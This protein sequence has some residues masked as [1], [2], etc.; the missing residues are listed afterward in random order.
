MSNTT[1]W[2]WRF[3]IVVCE[4]TIVPEDCEDEVIVPEDCEDDPVIEIIPIDKYTDDIIDDL[5]AHHN[6][7]YGEFRWYIADTDLVELPQK[8]IQNPRWLGFKQLYDDGRYLSIGFW[9]WEKGNQ[10]AKRT[11][12]TPEQQDDMNDILPVCS[13]TEPCRMC[14]KCDFGNMTAEQEDQIEEDTIEYVM[15]CCDDNPPCY[16]WECRGCR[17]SYL[18]TKEESDVLYPEHKE[19]DDR[20][21][22]HMPVAQYKR[23]KKIQNFTEEEFKAH[24]R[25]PCSPCEAYRWKDIV[26]WTIA[27]VMDITTEYEPCGNCIFCDY[28]N[29]T[30]EQQAALFSTP[31]IK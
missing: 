13:K 18:M 14:M 5:Y 29:M 15:L 11:E 8:Q 12:S 24:F 22:E 7:L 19:E 10:R 2:C 6:W 28:N 30:A 25:R 21:T 4:D 1:V 17:I 23:M 26:D 31:Y 20:P 3:Y 16:K 9:D 27:G